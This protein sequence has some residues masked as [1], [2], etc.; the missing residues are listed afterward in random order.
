MSG[1]FRRRKKCY[2]SGVM[3]RRWL[4]VFVLAGSLSA[5]TARASAPSVAPRVLAEYPHDAGAFTQGLVHHDGWFYESTGL[6]GSSSL[7]RVAPATGAVDIS[8]ALAQTEFGEGLALVGDRLI[9]LTWQE[10][11]AHVYRLESF[12]PLTD[13]E[14]TGEGWGL[15]F[16][17]LQLIMTDGS[18]QLSFR[19]PESFA[20]LGSQ[21]VSDDG[22]PV[23][24]LNELECVDGLVLA[25][26]WM[27]DRIAVIDPRTGRVLQW[28]DA[29]GL[30]TE[31]EA[32]SA[33]VLNGI[34]RDATSGHFYVTGKLWPKLFEVELELPRAASNPEQE[35]AP[36]GR[37]SER[38][39]G[40]AMCSVAQRSSQ[41]LLGAGWLLVLSLV[42]WRRLSPGGARFRAG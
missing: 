42:V 21:R 19:D 41:N 6:R 38:P 4:G 13:H 3:Q 11:V 30:L 9:Q 24:Q 32:A 15:C 5:S 10:E 25:N 23:E 18:D 27:T 12:E 33:D 31:E 29:R 28:V 22:V 8:V 20:L 2:G 17:G 34:A 40:C 1:G 37:T 26:V 39:R 14:Y 16:D 7:R 36:P 35:P